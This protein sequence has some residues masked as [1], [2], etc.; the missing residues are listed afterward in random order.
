[1]PQ[2]SSRSSNGAVLGALAVGSAVAVLV[3]A[4]LSIAL[5]FVINDLGYGGI[6]LVR[7]A[8]ALFAVIVGACVGAP[9]LVTR[10]SGP[11]APLLAAPAALVAGVLGDVIGLSV[12]QLFSGGLT[13]TRAVEFYFRS[14]GN[15]DLLGMVILLLAPATAAGVAALRV[16]TAGKKQ[17]SGGFQ[18]AF[19]QPGQPGPYGQP[20]PPAGQF[21]QPMQP[22][23]PAPYAAP[24]QPGQFPPPG[25]PGAPAP[26]Q[27]A[28][29]GQ[30]APPAPP[31]AA[32]QPASAAQPYQPPAPQPGQYAPPPEPPAQPSPPP[33]TSLDQP[34]PPSDSGPSQQPSN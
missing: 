20:Q 7:A 31:A 21:G 26:G 9:V 12:Y 19:G 25:Q 32:D 33:A 23:H 4:V 2:P 1:M 3:G 34:L 10:P 15:M 13:V 8:N 5:S 29:Y 14:Y 27:P 11:I 28:P 24:G 18:P 30:Y 6:G 16:V 17:Q 22:G